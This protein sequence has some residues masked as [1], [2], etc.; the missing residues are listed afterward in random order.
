M[1]CDRSA[2]N[3]CA[4]T[5]ASRASP[6]ATVRSVDVLEDHTGLFGTS[7]YTSTVSVSSSQPTDVQSGS[8]GANA[9]H[10]RSSRPVLLESDQPITPTELGSARSVSLFRLPFSNVSSPKRTSCMN[11]TRQRGY[12]NA[13]PSILGNQHSNIVTKITS[14]HIRGECI[15]NQASS[16]GD[17]TKAHR[18][19]TQGSGGLPEQ[20]R[21]RRSLGALQALL[22]T[23]INDMLS[24]RGSNHMACG[25]DEFGVATY[26][27]TITFWRSSTEVTESGF[28]KAIR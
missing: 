26:Y 19:T 15:I 11:L 25:R 13:L 8:G 9:G 23:S 21:S 3:A 7:S 12:Q 17:R 10:R 4:T 16:G 6:H 1:L 20:L 5:C 28:S 27:A 14:M 2:G 24:T 18:V 22:D